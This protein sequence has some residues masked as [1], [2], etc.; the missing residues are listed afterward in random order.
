MVDIKFR[1]YDRVSVCVQGL[2]YIYIGSFHYND[3]ERIRNR[4]LYYRKYPTPEMVQGGFWYQVCRALRTNPNCLIEN[5]REILTNWWNL[6]G[7]C[8]SV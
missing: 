3:I 2:K 7:V 8:Y 4:I 6:L 1:K 5:R